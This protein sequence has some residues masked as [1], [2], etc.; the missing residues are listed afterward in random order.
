MIITIYICRANTWSPAVN[1]VSRN[2][3]ISNFQTYF[4]SFGIK[5]GKL[6]SNSQMTKQQIAEVQIIV[7]TTEK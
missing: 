2:C 5:V 3:D 6:T 7:A 4:K 1:E